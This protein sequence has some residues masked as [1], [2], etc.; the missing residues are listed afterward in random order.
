L[1]SIKLRPFLLRLWS[2]GFGH[3]AL[4]TGLWLLGFGHWAYAISNG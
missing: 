4:V 2:L 1:I 3:W